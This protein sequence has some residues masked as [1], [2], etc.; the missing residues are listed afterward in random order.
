MKRRTT[1]TR[2]VCLLATLTGATLAHGDDLLTVYD[3]AAVNDPQIREAEATRMASREA[4]PQAIARLLP[5]FSGQATKGRDWS[6]GTSISSTFIAG[7][8]TPTGSGTRSKSDSESWGLN[9]RQNVFSWANWTTLAAANNQV[10]QAEANYL[11]AQQSLAQRV[12]QQ[13]F[14]VLNAQDN[15]E[16]QEAARDAVSRQLEQAER[17]F[18]VGLIAITDVQEARAERDNAAAQVIAAK[19]ALSSAQELLRATIGVQANALNKPADTMPLIS[20]DPARVEDWVRIS[21]EQN[22]ALTSSRLAADI[23]RDNVHTS[24]ADHLPTLDLVAGRTHNE[25]DGDQ[26]F[27]NLD[28]GVVSATPIDTSNYGKTVSLQ[29]TVPIFSGGATQSRVRQSQYNWIAAKERLER[30]S[31]DTE[32]QAR[33][34]YLGVLSEISR[35]QALKQALESSQTALKATEAGYDVGTRTAVDVLISRRTLIQAQTSYSS[36]RY[37]YLNTLIQLRLASGNL[38]RKTLEEINQWLTV[39]GPAPAPAQ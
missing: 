2:L 35:V 38:D 28:T 27:R 24:F 15:V 9:L 34:A 26:T 1:R 11:V 37:S 33:D 12:A 13:Y 8:P 6:N 25:R 32:R 5:S 10:A 39:A 30:T 21:M 29:L 22:A 17:R 23:A 4:R 3:Q 18:E 31:R 16:A 20:P 7:V 19:R 14:S 36:A